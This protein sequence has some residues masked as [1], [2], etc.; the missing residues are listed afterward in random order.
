M[1]LCVFTGRLIAD[2][3]LRYSQNGMAVCKFKMAIDRP[4]KKGEDKKADFPQFLAFGKTAEFCANY[5]KK[6]FRETVWAQFQTGSYEKDG[7]KHYTNDFIVNKIY[8]IDWPEKG[9]IVSHS[10]DADISGINLDDLPM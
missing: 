2:P 4:V 3:E 10:N 8:P 9:Q 6:G 1:N 5:F 7:Q